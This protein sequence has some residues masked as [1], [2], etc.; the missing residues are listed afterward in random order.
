MRTLQ[1]HGI[2]TFRFAG[3][4]TAKGMG[5]LVIASTRSNVRDMFRKD[6]LQREWKLL[7]Y[8]AGS[9]FVHLYLL[10]GAMESEAE[11]CP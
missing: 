11:Q 10:N 8:A 1:D 5:L 4:R 7:P 9:V 3:Q 2:S 6:N